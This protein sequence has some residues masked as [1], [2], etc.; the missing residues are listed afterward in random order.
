M[1][2]SRFAHFRFS[3]HEASIEIDLPES[4]HLQRGLMT[5]I[6][7]LEVNKRVALYLESPSDA[8]LKEIRSLHIAFR[9]MNNS[10]AAAFDIKHFAKVEHS[11]VDLANL[12]IT[13]DPNFTH[14]TLPAG[15]PGVSSLKIEI[16]LPKNLEVTPDIKLS[17][18]TIEYAKLAALNAESPNPILVKDMKSIVLIVEGMVIPTLNATTQLGFVSKCA[19]FLDQLNKEVEAKEKLAKETAYS[20][21]N[22]KLTVLG[23]SVSKPDVVINQNQEPKPRFCNYL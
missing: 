5:A 15:Y 23:N 20:K 4:I 2:I 7:S 18:L 19:E 8:L 14:L 3:F 17:I 21:D 13:T 9:K 10:S 22:V 11:P 16:D 12:T 6:I 1:T